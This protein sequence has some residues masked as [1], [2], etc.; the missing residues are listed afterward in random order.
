MDLSG[1][2]LSDD[3]SNQ[4]KWTFTS[5]AVV[6]AKGYLIV[7]CDSDEDEGELHTNFDLSQTGEYIGLY[8]PVADG[9]ALVDSLEFPAVATDYSYGRLPD[10][11]A[12]WEVLAPATPGE[13]NRRDEQGA[14]GAR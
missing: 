14:G 1:W 3:S 6:P 13:A 5:G 10:G 12:N 4:L 2:T 11:A 9:G 7:L 8:A